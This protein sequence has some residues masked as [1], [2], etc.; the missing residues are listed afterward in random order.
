MNTSL[1]NSGAIGDSRWGTSIS[2]LLF[3]LISIIIALPVGV[4]LARFDLYLTVAAIGALAITNLIILRQDL[5]AATLILAVRLYFDWYLGFAFIAPI[6]AAVLVCT[7]FLFRSPRFPW[8]VPRALWL[9][10][11]WL[12]IAIFPSLHGVNSLDST[13]YYFNIIAAPLAMFWLGT[14]LAR[15]KASI[16]RLF[17]LL[18]AFATLIAIITIIEAVTG[19]LLF[20]SSRFDVALALSSNFDLGTSSG[21]TNISRAGAY[22]VN[23]DGNGGF[24]AMMLFIPFGLL[25]Q[26]SSPLQK[27][28]YVAEILLISLA[29]VYTY[30]VGALIAAL[31]G[32]VAFTLLL[33]RT[34][35]R[36]LLPLCVA[37]AV[38]LFFVLF[39]YQIG[40]LIGHSQA[41]R[42]WSG[43][44][45]AWE[46]GI[47]VIAAFPL[48][49]IGL[50]RYVYYVRGNPFRVP[51]QNGLLSHPHNSYLELAALGGLPL[52]IVFIVLFLFI[53]CTV[54]RHWL[55]ADVSTRTLIASG[56]AV[57]VALS[58]Y[59]LSA[60]GWTY[61][62]TETVG[63]LVFGVIS[64][65]LLLKFRKQPITNSQH[66]KAE[67]SVNR[68]GETQ[69][70]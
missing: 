45:G 18:A 57:V 17:N 52:G 6:A 10:G 51:A 69:H 32:F 34:R 42:E 14:L 67:H 58:V 49:G 59:S 38:L 2:S 31:G 62:P 65:P 29:L 37:G 4:I 61:V 23:P 13:Y 68:L 26:K 41:P 53:V 1:W 30:S 27:V 28:L 3:P 19:A 7:Y 66:D 50:G 56:L 15:D 46:T 39:P 43:R 60:T 36:L 54:L 48:T 5:L 47:R 11:V 21:T 70:A 55:Q 20:K 8:A 25:L 24:C 40:L 12:I 16:V 35:H 9:W 33:G 64:S 44:I 63:W 22:F